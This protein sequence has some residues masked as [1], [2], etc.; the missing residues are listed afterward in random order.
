MAAPKRKKIRRKIDFFKLKQDAAGY[1]DLTIDSVWT[2]LASLTDED[3]VITYT[4]GSKFFHTDASDKTHNRLMLSMS[5]RRDRP[6]VERDLSLSDL[7]IAPEEG[8][9]TQTHMVFFPPNIVGVEYRKNGAKIGHL[10][11]I[12]NKCVNFGFF[13]FEACIEKDFVDKL[14][15]M[16]YID[17][18]S[19]R[20]NRSQIDVIEK[21][22]AGIASGVR[23]ELEEAEAESI[24]LLF[25]CYTQLPNKPKPK[26]KTPE[27]KDVIEGPSD[28][29]RALQ[30]RDRFTEKAKGV[31]LGLSKIPEMFGFTKVHGRQE[32]G[33]PIETFDFMQH[34]IVGQS[35]SI[36]ETASFKIDSEDMYQSI[37]DSYEKLKHRLDDS[38]TIS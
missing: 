16:K 2:A 17:W 26:K 36:K 28:Y 1:P 35:R 31:I 33:S 9:S 10:E 6:S 8:V 21:A 29:E 25:R 15:K 5:S 13:K 30:K 11:Q 12:L 4:D 22:S 34:K 23:A 38:P 19:L 27:N 20:V 24:D 3:R 18:Y 7:P 32:E 37:I 14:S